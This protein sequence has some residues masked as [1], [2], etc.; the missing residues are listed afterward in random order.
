MTRYTSATLG[1]LCLTWYAVAYPSL[2]GYFMLDIDLMSTL[3]N[4]MEQYG[5]ETC[6]LFARAIFHLWELPLNLLVFE[7]LG[8]DENGTKLSSFC[9]DLQP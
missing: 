8:S 5:I 2:F 1:G 9:T 7:K 6:R 4:C 3:G